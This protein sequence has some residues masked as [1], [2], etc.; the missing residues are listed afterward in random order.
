MSKPETIEASGTPSTPQTVVRSQDAVVGQFYFTMILHPLNGW[1]RVGRP[2]AT[3]ATAQS[4]IP[5]VRKA[6]RGC[7]AKVETFIPKYENGEMNAESKRILSDRYNFDPPN[8][9]GQAPARSAAEG[10]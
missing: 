5:F 7:K 2:Y 8:P 10:R 4:W 6:W 3:R 9:T 1:I